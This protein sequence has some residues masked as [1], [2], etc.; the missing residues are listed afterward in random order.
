MNRQYRR[1]DPKVFVELC[2]GAG[3]ATLTTL[4][5]G[6]ADYAATHPEETEEIINAISQEVI[7][8]AGKTA[9]K[10]ANQTASRGW[11]VDSIREAV[12]NGQSSPAVNNLNPLNGATRFVNPTTGQSVV[13]DNV[14]KEVIHVGGPGFKY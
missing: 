10:W 8:G 3:A 11:T 1:P 14:T 13:I 2:P 5:I 9:D 4:G 7:F 6:G 12:I